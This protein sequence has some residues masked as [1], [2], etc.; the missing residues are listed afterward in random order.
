MITRLVPHSNKTLNTIK[1][2]NYLFITYLTGTSYCPV[3]V[4]N[5]QY[6]PYMDMQLLD[7]FIKCK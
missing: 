4:H 5:Q 1:T 3:S 6:R 7:E 2:I